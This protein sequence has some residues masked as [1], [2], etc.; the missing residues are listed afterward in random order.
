MSLLCTHKL[1]KPLPSHPFARGRLGR[2]FPPLRGVFETCVQHYNN[3][4]S[5]HV[6]RLYKHSQIKCDYLYRILDRLCSIQLYKSFYLL[7]Q[8]IIN[9]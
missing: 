9:I 6:W 1:S 7:E 5:T 2:G 4:K 8:T 3:L